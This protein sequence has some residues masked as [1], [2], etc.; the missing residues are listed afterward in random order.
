[1]KSQVLP[2]DI[3]Q[4]S[5][6]EGPPIERAVVLSVLRMENGASSNMGLGHTTPSSLAYTPLAYLF[7]VDMLI[8][9]TG[10]HMQELLLDMLMCVYSA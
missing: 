9:S 8:H 5:R 1:M 4:G 10:A 3:G 2:A 6:P 7:S